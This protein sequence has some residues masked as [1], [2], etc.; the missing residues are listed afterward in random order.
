M[1]SLHLLGLPLFYV[2]LAGEK[3][4]SVLTTNEELQE[5]TITLPMFLSFSMSPELKQKSLECTQSD[6]NRTRVCVALSPSDHPH[7]TPKVY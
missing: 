4:E 5:H 1:V 3:H 6:A 7:T 2:V